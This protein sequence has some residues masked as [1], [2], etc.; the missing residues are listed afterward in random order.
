VFSNTKTYLNNILK[1]PYISSELCVACGS[2]DVRYHF[3]GQE[4]C[5]CDE[6]CGRA[7]WESLSPDVQDTFYAD[8]E[9]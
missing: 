6:A 7:Y 4:L 2:A 5:V 8:D 3:V 1:I 9:K